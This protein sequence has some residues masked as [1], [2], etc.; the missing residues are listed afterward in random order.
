MIRPLRPREK[1]RQVSVETTRSASQALSRP[2]SK[3][4][5]VPPT[6]ATSTMP[7]RISPS[8]T[9]IAWPAEAQAEVT[10]KTGPLAQ[11][12]RAMREAGAEPMICGMVKGEGRELSRKILRKARPTAS[13]P[14]LAVPTT[15]ATRCGS[16]GFSSR[17]ASFHA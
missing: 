12:S 3:Q 6:T 5:S 9:I 10:P 7:A 13:M 4:L 8:P 17:P 2:I 15:T 16:G 14:V 11:S 1:G